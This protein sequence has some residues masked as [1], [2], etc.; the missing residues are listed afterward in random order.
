MSQDDGRRIK[1]QTSLRR[2]A[3]MVSYIIVCR[4]P[5]NKKL[6]IISNDNAA[7]DPAEFETEEKAY[8]RAQEIP[9]CR[10]WGAEIVPIGC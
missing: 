4:N 7:D 6:L 10:A 1:T 5:G 9:V 8:E 3:I 2:E